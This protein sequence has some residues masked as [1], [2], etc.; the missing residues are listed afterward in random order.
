MSLSLKAVLGIAALAIITAGNTVSATTE[1]VLVAADTIMDTTNDKA[2][3]IG[4]PL[5]AHTIIPDTNLKCG[6]KSNDDSTY[7]TDTNFSGANYGV[8][9][10]IADASEVK[11]GRI[12]TQTYVFNEDVQ[13]GKKF[14]SW[15]LLGVTNETCYEVV[16]S[17]TYTFKKYSVQCD[18]CS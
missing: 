6:R 3:S 1:Y 2:M 14:Q 8:Y 7:S 17:V 15:G 9:M 4:R 11:G 13:P 12:P 18:T 5:K 16:D 10:L